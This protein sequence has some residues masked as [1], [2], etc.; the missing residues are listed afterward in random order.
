MQVQSVDV[1]AQVMV[2]CVQNH[3]PSVIVIDEI[4][5]KEEV[6]AALTCKERGV[7]IIASA[8]GNMAGLVRNAEL[9][10][11]VG[12]VDVVTIGDETARRETSHQRYGGGGGDVSG[13]ST[14]SK[15]RAER[16]GPPIFDAVVE[17][18]RGKL[19]EWRLVY[20]SAAAVDSILKKG[21]YNAQVR[22]R[23][24]DSGEENPIR[25]QNITLNANRQDIIEE[26]SGRESIL[27]QNKLPPSNEE[28]D[29]S[30]TSL[31][32]YR[33]AATATSES[34]M[35]PLDS[36][37]TISSESSMPEHSSFDNNTPNKDKPAPTEDPWKKKCRKCPVCKRQ[38]S[39]RA[40]MVRHATAKASCRKKL[41]LPLRN[42]LRMELGLPP[43]LR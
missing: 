43:Y 18:Q 22:S 31:I 17:L 27:L 40:D 34:S 9:C 33:S 19:H 15:L 10:D 30:K 35:K 20:P 1:Q 23:Q 21:E 16:R 37:S 29:S 24:S 32:Q 3:T 26:A 25:V 41:D 4:G 38:F 12:G 5:R 28:E 8:H 42:K 36:Y 11:T 2:E 39:R 14:G 7:R 6:Q 13:T